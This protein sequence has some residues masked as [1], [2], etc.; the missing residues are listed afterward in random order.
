[1]I[2]GFG[3]C[4]ELTH[5]CRAAEEV[6]EASVKHT[7]KRAAQVLQ[8]TSAPAYRDIR[9]PDGYL[10]TIKPLL[11]EGN[12]ALPVLLELTKSPDL[13]RFERRLGLILAERIRHPEKFDKVAPYLTPSASEDPWAR[14]DADHVARWQPAMKPLSLDVIHP[15]DREGWK[16]HWVKYETVLDKYDKLLAK[17]TFPSSKEG[18]K[19]FNGR[20]E[21]LGDITRAI[22]AD[23]KIVYGDKHFLQPRLDPSYLLAW[24]EGM[25]RPVPWYARQFIIRYIHQ[26]GSPASM[27]SLGEVYRQAV[28]QMDNSK[29]DQTSIRFS[30][31]LWPLRGKHSARDAL[32]MFADTLG[33]ATD[34]G[35]L[36][37]ISADFGRVIQDPDPKTQQYRDAL[38][39]LGKDADCKSEYRVLE[40]AL[41]TYK[42]ERKKY[43]EE[44]KDYLELQRL[45]E[46][47]EKGEISD[48]EMEQALEKYL[49]TQKE[50]ERK[51]ALPPKSTP[52]NEKEK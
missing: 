9:E 35:V 50:K 6:T 4:P 21:E 48:S 45:M 14:F 7:L 19:L 1:V 40:Q 3:Y 8:T 36:D 30:G 34:R 43:D 31:A 37:R 29:G 10:E 44:N 5:N 52:A 18:V 33:A 46:K 17:L 12:K 38:Q 26:L 39:A 47:H 16:P 15:D 27:P 41:E 22:L 28:T 2:I 51:K 49:K 42:K 32:L 11:K 23:K 24:E 25:V 13:S 20:K